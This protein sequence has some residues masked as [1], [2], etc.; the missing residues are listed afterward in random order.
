MTI[1]F[2]KQALKDLD[3]FEKFF[4][5]IAQRIY[6]LLEDIEK[7]PFNRLGKPEPLRHALTGKWSRR[8]D[9]THRLVYEAHNEVV[10]VYSCR[11]HYQ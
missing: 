4:P 1:V 3:H 2:K 7:H 9:Y 6:Q 11:F 8:I 10:T 5:K